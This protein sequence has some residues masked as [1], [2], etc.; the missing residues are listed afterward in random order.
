MPAFDGSGPAGN[1]SMT[2]WGRGP[3]NGCGHA[4]RRGFGCKG[5]GGFF[6]FA[7][8]CNTADERTMLAEEVKVVSEYLKDLQTRLNELGE[9]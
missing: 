1:G 6:R 8:F 9:K 2:G 7:P 5:F 3:C 4:M